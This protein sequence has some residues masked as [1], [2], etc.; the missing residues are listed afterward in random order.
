MVDMFG[1]A[2]VASWSHMVTQTIVKPIDRCLALPRRPHSH[3][4]LVV[5]G[6]LN[7]DM[8]V[9]AVAVA[10]SS[11]RPNSSRTAATKAEARPYR[12]LGSKVYKST[13][14]WNYF[15][16]GIRSKIESEIQAYM[17]YRYIVFFIRVFKTYAKP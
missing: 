2:I 7:L 15:I 16:K 8:A 10:E 5:K 1:G 4:D 14:R 9:T 12:L 17:P 3:V 11:E 6:S 13:N